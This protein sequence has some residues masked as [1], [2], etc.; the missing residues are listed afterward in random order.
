[1]PREGFACK[2]LAQEALSGHVRGWRQARG[3]TQAEGPRGGFTL[4]ER[5][6][7]QCKVPWE[8]SKGAG[9]ADLCICPPVVKGPPWQVNSYVL[10]AVC[11][12][13]CSSVPRAILQRW[14]TGVGVGSKV[15][16]NWPHKNSKTQ[17][18]PLLKA[19]QR[20]KPTKEDCV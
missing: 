4:M 20:Q 9:L 7:L 17:H 6:I 18:S 14:I 1:M 10:P 12:G 16:P 15:C 11:V 3:S 5:G 13:E 8:L 2:R 19:I